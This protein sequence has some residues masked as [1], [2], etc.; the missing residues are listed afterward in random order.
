MPRTI[1]ECPEFQEVT[2]A[3][4]KHLMT[5]GPKRLDD[6]LYPAL[7]AQGLNSGR[8]IGATDALMPS[9]SAWWPEPPCPVET[10]VADEETG[11]TYARWPIQ[12]RDSDEESLLASQPEDAAEVRAYFQW[13]R[14]NQERS[15]KLHDIHEAI[16]RAGKARRLQILRDVVAELES[17]LPG[18]VGR[19]VS[20]HCADGHQCSMA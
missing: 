19:L 7:Q 8:D 14:R 3:G 13:K 20:A 12:G 16:Y 18:F 5:P 6:F 1:P 4:V 17:Q 2:V 9:I 10:T 11:Q 15:E